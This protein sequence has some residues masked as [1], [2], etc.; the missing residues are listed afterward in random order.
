VIEGSFPCP[1][2]GVEQDAWERFVRA[3]A[4]GKRLGAVSE[5]NA[6]GIF[7]LRPRRLADL[8]ILR[9]LRRTQPGEHGP[10]AIWIGC[11][12]DAAFGVQ[13]RKRFEVQYQVFCASVREHADRL[14]SG[15]L[16]RP[17]SLT[18]S[19]ALAALHRAG[20]GAL[21]RL[22]PKTAALVESANGLF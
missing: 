4:T 13:L 9:N 14:M 22:N 11:F 1:I 15:A 12:V 10:K 17:E 21:E 2:D 3:C 8:G 18:L 6:L 19:G 20:E 16:K 7:E 5:T